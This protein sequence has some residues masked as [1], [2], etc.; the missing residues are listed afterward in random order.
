MALLAIDIGG[1]FT[2][3]MAFD[4]AAGFYQAKS[5]TTPDDFAQGIIDCIEK[6]GL[7]PAAVSDLIH[8][9]TVAIN[10][11]IERKG[12]NTGLIVTRGTRDVYAIG[13]GNR[14]ES[15]N[16][17]FHRPRTLVPRHLTCEIDERVMASGEVLTRP[18]RAQIEAVCDKF[19]KAGVESVAVCFLHSYTN[20]GHE[21]MVGEVLK[22]RLPEIY[23]SLS[24]EVLREF[25]EYER[26]ST[27]VVNSYIGPRVSGY[28]H[29]LEARLADVGFEGDLAIMQSN[30]GVMSPEVAT[31]RPAAMMES[32]PVGGIIASA[33]IGQALGY[34]N[35]IS[36]DMGG[37]TAKSSLVRGGE[38]TMSEGYYVGGYANG[39]PVML[40]VVDVVEIGAGGGSIAWIDEVGALKV[41]PQSSG[42]DPGPIC[43][44]GGGTEPT[45]TDA[46][47]ILGR[48]GATDFLGGEMPLDD[49]AA[50]ELTA[51]KLCRE[52]GMSEI[53]TAHAIV[54]IAL[55]K[56][57]LAV[58]E[59]SVEKGY[60]PRDFALVASGG[61]GPLHAVAIARE[62]HIPTVVIPR[63]PAHFSALGMLMADERHDFTRT[64]FA[65]LEAVDFAALQDIFRETRGEAKK[66]LREM[67]EIDYQIQLD[68][69]Y[70]GQEFTLSVPVTEAQLEA[71][72]AGAIRQAFNQLH[73]QRYAHSASD[74]PVEMVNFR[75]IAL[76]RRPHMKNPA[77]DSSAGGQ[78]PAKHRPVYFDDPGAPVD[79]PV[80][81]RGDLGA[82]VRIEGPALVQEYA[83]TTVLFNEDACTI[84]PTGEMIISLRSD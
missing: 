62:L 59:V 8:G 33:K 23:V 55:A 24:H 50:F 18:D 67:P 76:G 4:D 75:L 5:L 15:Y 31:R 78:Q 53:E 2:D 38:T 49:A 19:E 46:N 61:A 72:D 11:L 21:R 68:L 29:N 17:F 13:R 52:L 56:M 40:P 66:V 43:Y 27:T 26:T 70:V 20:P 35:V 39:H 57:S 42:A 22:E 37:T 82:G 73:E 63:F 14:P 48:I 77:L 51:E 83:S 69:R 80:Y 30:G 58:R 3:L 81:F 25:R 74:E 41:G 1:T 65:P 36:F 7:D 54:E 84:A 9:T 6:C 79:C 44:G 32:G 16:L 47:V 34:A 12:A 64:Y 71:G 28:V 10:T 60:D 45:I